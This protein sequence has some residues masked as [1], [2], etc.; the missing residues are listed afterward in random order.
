MD[1]GLF[2]DG[3][4]CLGPD[5]L[6]VVQEGVHDDRWWYYDQLSSAQLSSSHSHVIDANDRPYESAKVVD[7]KRGE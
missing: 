3:A 4:A 2:M 5:L 1:I 7:K 6:A